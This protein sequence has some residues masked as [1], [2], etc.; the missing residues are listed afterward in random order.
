MVTLNEHVELL[1]EFVA[2]HVTAV[3]PAGNV[4]PL[5]G[6]QITVAA[7]EPV[8]DGSVHEARVLSH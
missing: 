3:V 8:D 5:A 1:H 7:G 4:L 2:V 6:V